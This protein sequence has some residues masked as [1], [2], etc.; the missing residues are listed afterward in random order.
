MKRRDF[1]K[2]GGATAILSATPAPWVLASHSH[3]FK[4]FK[5]LV[6]IYLA[7][8]N[9]GFNMIVP[10]DKPHFQQYEKARSDLALKR[11]HIL[12]IPTLATDRYFNSVSLGLHPSMAS[13]QPLF[14]QGDANVVLNSGILIQP[15]SKSKI[16]KGHA[17]PPQL[18]SH[19]S[20]A[21]EWFKG[22]VGMNN[23]YGWAGRMMDVLETTGEI[24]PSF[25]LGRESAWLRGQQVQQNVVKIGKITK[26]RMLDKNKNTRNSF[27]RMNDKKPLSPFH[28]Y[29]S[30]VRGQA[31]VKS[32]LL[33]NHLS[34]ISDS[35]SLTSIGSLGAQLN[36]VLK[37][38]K[39]SSNFEHKRQVYFV[40]LKGFDTHD[41][42]LER[43]PVLLKELSDA[44]S[45]FYAEL[46]LLGAQSQVTTFTMSD[47]GRR[48]AANGQGSDHGWG[49]HQLLFGG[50]LN[51][52]KA[53]GVFPDIRLKGEDDMGVGRI[54][55]SLSNEQV[56]ATLAKWMGVSEKGMSYVFPNLRNFAVHDLHFF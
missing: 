5:A 37:L 56:G 53:V 11:E 8:G 2:A 52:K 55:P 17:L 36:T 12:P 14:R 31:L 20:Q 15:L 44:V 28:E 9:D 42:Q 7:G 18:F 45:T 48:I 29:F 4:D 25:S 51:A 47:F 34:V 41:N 16:K 27:V 33:A 50:A 35:A 30:D 32:D 13:L 23:P 19:N 6:C 46:E 21:G 10:V 43:H 54:I 26:L 38:I 39:L 3:S 22:A 24:E 1:L 40:R 49:S